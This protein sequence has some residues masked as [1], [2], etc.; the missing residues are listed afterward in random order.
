MIP[1]GPVHDP[2]RLLSPKA[3]SDVQAAATAFRELTGRRMVV[4]I[5]PEGRAADLPAPD[6]PAGEPVGIVYATTPEDTAGRLTIIDPAWRKVLP[7][8]WGFMFPQ[9]LAQKY[10]AEVFERRVVLSAQYL[11]KVFPDKL[12]FVLKPR[13]G[14][15]SPGSLKFSRGAYLGIEI[16]G[17]FIIFFTA[18]R[19]LWPAR[20]R[21]ED[22]D[23]FSNELRR[24]KKERQ[25]W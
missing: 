6:L 10:G 22:Q 25:I 24:L 23:P 3:S 15:L 16:L 13:G 19:T 2:N 17:Y 4:I 9:R 1:T 11:A 12:A 5:L 14:E 21:E 18:V 8:Q 20:L 7:A